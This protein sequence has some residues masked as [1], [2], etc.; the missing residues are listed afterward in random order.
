MIRLC[1]FFIGL[2]VG[3]SLA[4]AKE[5]PFSWKGVVP[6]APS[7]LSKPI[8][9][10]GNKT[11]ITKMLLSKKDDHPQITMSSLIHET[12]GTEIKILKANL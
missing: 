3:M 8:T 7:T 4:V 2:I 9:T 1:T 11:T 5:V 10:E 12:T 6:V